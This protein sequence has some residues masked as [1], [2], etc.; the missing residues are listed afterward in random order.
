MLT[1]RSGL[2]AATGELEDM[3][4]WRSL[5]SARAGEDGYVQPELGRGETLTDFCALHHSQT[6]F[7]PLS[8][9]VDATQIEVIADTTTQS[10]WT[11]GRCP[12]LPSTSDVPLESVAGKGCLMVTHRTRPTHPIP[13]HHA[14]PPPRRQLVLFGVHREQF[15]ELRLMDPK[16]EPT[17]EQLAYSDMETAK[18]TRRRVER[19]NCRQLNLTERHL[20][21]WQQVWP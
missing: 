10:G 2:S 20:V 15:D 6:R 4:S 13:S 3:T 21:S 14:C 9:G 11:H 1:L 18:W 5:A 8:T 12:R 17:P 7:R 19:G 16:S